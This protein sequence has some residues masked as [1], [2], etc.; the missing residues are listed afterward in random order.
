MI[1]CKN[2]TL[3]QCKQ[4]GLCNEF[5]LSFYRTV[6]LAMNVLQSFETLVLG[7][8]LMI[9]TSLENINSP[10]EKMQTCPLIQCAV[11]GINGLPS[12]DGRDGPKGE[13]GDKGTIL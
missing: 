9:A 11:P 1:H 6:V 4:R 5:W 12:R 10:E 2:I 13:K 8:S 3:K 7:M